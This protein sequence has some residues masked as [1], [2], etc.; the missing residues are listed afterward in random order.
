MSLQQKTD[1]DLMYDISSGDQKAFGI[2]L[3]RHLDF[4]VLYVQKRGAADPEEVVQESFI[5]VWQFAR[6]YSSEKALFKTWFFK[7]L[8]N[9]LN[10]SY[11]KKKRHGQITGFDFSFF[12]SNE[13]I[14]A[15]FQKKEE[16]A[17][18]L[19]TIEKLSSKLKEVFLLKYVN[20][21]KDSEIADCLGM[22]VKAVES[23]LLRARKIL[24]KNI[25]E[26]EK[27]CVKI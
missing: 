23:R 27:T 24:S 4:A 22:S 19:K 1:E 18:L 17:L 3:K 10:R 21:L 6:R 16:E 12:E 9:E 7:I 25:Q 2:L 15:S 13:N 5:R 11:E 20:Q 14:E 8:K 26:G